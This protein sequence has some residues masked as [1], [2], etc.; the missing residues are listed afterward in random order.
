MKKDREYSRKPSVSIDTAK[1]EN[2]RLRGAPQ[3]HVVPILNQQ[4][5]FD[6]RHS[7]SFESITSD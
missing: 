7:V 5:Y 4:R 6:M 1:Q 3:K 2:S